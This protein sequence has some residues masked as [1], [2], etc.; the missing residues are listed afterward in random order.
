MANWAIRE[1]LETL[2]ENSAWPR[3]AEELAAWLA[4][5]EGQIL[6]RWVNGKHQDDIAGI[7]YDA[8]AEAIWILD[9]GGIVRDVATLTRD[10]DGTHFTYEKRGR[11]EYFDIWRLTRQYLPWTPTDGTTTTGQRHGAF[12]LTDH[13]VNTSKPV[14]LWSDGNPWQVTFGPA[15]AVH[16][17]TDRGP[18]TGQWRLQGNFIAVELKDGRRHAWRWLNVAHAAG[19]EMPSETIDPWEVPQ[20]FTAIKRAIMEKPKSASALALEET[21]ERIRRKTEMDRQRIKATEARQE[22]REAAKR[23]QSS[24][25]GR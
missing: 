15:N 21:L 4:D 19:F 20:R 22:A 18:L 25:E 12:L 5:K 8:K 10:E 3:N 24:H 7:V 2:R 9:R 1:E 16:A 6:S 17:D 23:L 13:L 14:E 11:V